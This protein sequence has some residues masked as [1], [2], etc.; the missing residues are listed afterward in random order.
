MAEITLS[1]TRQQAIL[2]EFALQSLDQAITAKENR[3]RA[4]HLLL[5]RAA[6]ELLVEGGF[7][8]LSEQLG[9]PDEEVQ[10]A[11]DRV[12]ARAQGI[13]ASGGRRT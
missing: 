5:G 7:T 10:Q 12:T 6:L 11:G 8:Y 2:V 1:M 3:E 4:T 9:M 13:H